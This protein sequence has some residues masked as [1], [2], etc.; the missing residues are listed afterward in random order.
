MLVTG[1]VLP[2]QAIRVFFM[3][4]SLSLQLQGEPE[5]QL[6][7]TRSEDLIKTDDVL[8]LNNSDLIACMVV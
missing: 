7:L 5:T 4:R 3:L 8:D 1:V 6:P 2:L